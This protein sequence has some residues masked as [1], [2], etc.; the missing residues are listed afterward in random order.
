MYRGS[1]PSPSWA[2]WSCMAAA[3]GGG[4]NSEKG[5]RKSL[6]APASAGLVGTS[7]GGRDAARY[8]SSPRTEGWTPRPSHCGNLAEEKT[9]V[10]LVLPARRWMRSRAASTRR[11]AASTACLSLC[12]R[13]AIAPITWSAASESCSSA[14]STPCSASSSLKS[15]D[16]SAIEIRAPA[17]GGARLAI[18]AGRAYAW[19]WW[20]SCG[21]YSPLPPENTA[22][23]ESARCG[24]TA[25]PGSRCFPSLRFQRKEPSPLPLLP[26]RIPRW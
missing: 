26:S 10:A 25:L 22:Q 4:L 15:C 6:P 19:L 16:T 17:E 9:R 7:R 14:S 18:R 8:G 2:V 24:G 23:R 20:C 21:R 5:V 1:L 3:S 12:T 11:R 13:A